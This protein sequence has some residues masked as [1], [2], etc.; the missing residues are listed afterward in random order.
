MYMFDFKKLLHS[1]SG[2]IIISVLLGLGLASLFKMSCDNQKC[3]K[4]IGPK[5]SELKT[6]N[7]KYG[8]KCYSYKEKM[9]T[10]DKHKKQVEF[11]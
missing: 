10:C 9:E 6:K 2:R 4:F 8:D 3:V 5:P 7:Y 1:E 11:S